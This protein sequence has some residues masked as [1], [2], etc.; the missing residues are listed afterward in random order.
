M[1]T[2]ATATS[3]S[4]PTASARATTGLDR[5]TM[6]GKRFAAAV[7]SDPL[8]SGGYP[9][10]GGIQWPQEWRR[11]PRSPPARPAGS[12]HD[13]RL[14]P[15]RAQLARAQQRAAPRRHR[16]LRPPALDAPAVVPRDRQRAGRQEPAV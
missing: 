5:A 13:R 1:T 2:A 7:S 6:A 14:L 12:P 8:D 15:H 10:R 3:A 11:R 16:R 4:A 9:Y